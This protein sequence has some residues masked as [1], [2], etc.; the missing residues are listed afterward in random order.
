MTTIKATCPRCGE[1]T[2]TPPDIDLRVDASGAQ[3]SSYAFACPSCD[4]YV[5]KPAD[6]RIV[7]LLISGGVEV[8]EP[9]PEVETRADGPALT[10]DDL[11]DFHHLLAGDDWFDDLLA[12]S[13]DAQ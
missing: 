1:I 6:E 7:R 2:L 11:L 3:G 5:R 10:Y 4:G 9:E 12:E 8:L 13:R